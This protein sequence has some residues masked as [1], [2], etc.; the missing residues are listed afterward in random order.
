MASKQRRRK[1]NGSLPKRPNSTMVPSVI[2]SA[3]MCSAL[4]PP[5]T[6]RRTL[7]KATTRTSRISWEHRPAL[8]SISIIARSIAG[9]SRKTAATL[10]SVALPQPLE[11]NSS[12]LPTW[13]ARAVCRAQMAGTRRVPPTIMNSFSQQTRSSPHATIH[14]CRDWDDHP[15]L[16]NVRRGRRRQAREEVFR[17]SGRRGSLRR[18]RSLVSRAERAMRLPRANLGGDAQALSL[19]RAG[20]VR[21]A[22]T[23]LHLQ[24]RLEHQARRRHHH[25]LQ[26]ERLGQRRRRPANVRLAV[27]SDRLLSLFGRSGR[28]RASSR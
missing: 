5:Q 11:V 27:E 28:H 10:P 6:I 15:A 3:R 17:P 24:R 16:H 12:E 4:W 23:A 13:S 22:G 21:H 9:P 25:Q 14:T 20:Q 18:D 19:D 7:T 2:A 26:P 1:I 8:L